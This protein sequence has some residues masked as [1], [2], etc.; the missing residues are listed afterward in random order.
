MCRCRAM[1]NTPLVSLDLT[2]RDGTTRRTYVLFAGGRY[3]ITIGNSTT[4]RYA[5]HRELI[6][7]NPEW[8]HIV[9]IIDAA[10]AE[11]GVKTD[12]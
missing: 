9:P 12:G 11:L 6:G 7:S 4:Y 5:W 3:N 10:F 8:A 1:G 2:S